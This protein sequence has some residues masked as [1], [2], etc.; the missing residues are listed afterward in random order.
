M[1]L[2]AL[3]VVLLAMGMPATLIPLMGPAQAAIQTG[4]QTASFA[5]STWPRRSAAPYRLGAVQ[6]IPA[7]G[8][9]E[10]RTDVP[11]AE[12]RV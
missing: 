5:A 4:V 7:A 12:G 2:A 3:S 9:D 11:R 1:W 10:S 6:R 8:R